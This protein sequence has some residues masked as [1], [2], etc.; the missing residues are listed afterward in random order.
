[1]RGWRG[2]RDDQ[3]GGFTSSS[4]DLVSTYQTAGTE[5][6]PKRRCVDPLCDRPMNREERIV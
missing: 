3:P 6:L 1:M 5:L 2:C 4:L